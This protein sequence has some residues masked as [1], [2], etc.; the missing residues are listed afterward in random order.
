MLSRWVFVDV[1]IKLQQA[2]KKPIKDGAP[3]RIRTVDLVLRRHTLYPSELRAQSE[4]NSSS[5]DCITF[6]WWVAMNWGW[7][8]VEVQ[9]HHR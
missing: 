7:E 6:G 9:K 2:E 1:E 5:G 3:G 4:I 8:L